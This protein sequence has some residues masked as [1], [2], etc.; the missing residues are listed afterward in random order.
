MDAEMQLD[1]F[2]A[3]AQRVTAIARARRTDPWPSHAAADHVERTG[4]AGQQRIRCGAAVLKN[5]GKTSQE[6]SEITGIDRYEL[7]RRLPELRA[8]GLIR[9]GAE[10]KI[11]NIT[12]RPAMTWEPT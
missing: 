1:L 2:S 12:G 4:K 6:L 7:A 3:A 8:Q 11:C 10:T 5:S 9:N